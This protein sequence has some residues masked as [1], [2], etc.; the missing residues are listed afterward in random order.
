MAKLP[1]PSSQTNQRN[2]R[3]P[4]L[5]VKV[6]WHPGQVST[7]WSGP[8]KP[9]KSFTQ[10]TS[11]LTC[12]FSVCG[13]NLEKTQA[14]TGKTCT[15]KGPGVKPTASSW[16]SN[17]MNKN[18]LCIH[19]FLP[20]YFLPEQSPKSTYN[21]SAHCHTPLFLRIM[22]LDDFM[23]V[24]SPPCFISTPELSVYLIL[25]IY[26]NMCLWFNLWEKFLNSHQK[27]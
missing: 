10:V 16:N 25:C 27:E 24:P 8:H 6:D 15:Q 18:P 4:A 20:L 21:N 12:L 11:H 22:D 17:C 26:S 7:S 19:C 13:R 14:D 1:L 3:K 5:R 23:L 9:Q 2:R